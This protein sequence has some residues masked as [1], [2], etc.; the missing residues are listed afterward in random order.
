MHKKL[1]IVIS[2]TVDL[3]F[4]V[5]ISF[6]KNNGFYFLTIK[7]IDFFMDF[8]SILKKILMYLI[9]MYYLNTM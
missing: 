9:N 4:L 8:V 1:K 7:M 2:E 5:R 3:L 6:S